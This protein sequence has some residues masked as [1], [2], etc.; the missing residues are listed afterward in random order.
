MRDMPYGEKLFF[1]IRTEEASALT[2]LRHA[3]SF[4]LGRL[5]LPDG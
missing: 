4:S 2:D 5:E 3:A 1:L